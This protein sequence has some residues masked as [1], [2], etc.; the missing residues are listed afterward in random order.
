MP[1]GLPVEMTHCHVLQQGKQQLQESCIE[2][3]PEAAAAVAPEQG[4][5]GQAEA[6]ALRHNI[7]Q[8]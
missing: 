6:C 3:A 1:L 5:P 8:Y 7:H 4:A 2:A